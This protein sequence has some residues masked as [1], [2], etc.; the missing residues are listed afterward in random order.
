MNARKACVSFA[1]GIWTTVGPTVFAAAFA[2]DGLVFFHQQ[3]EPILR[4]RCFGCHSHRADPMEGG[5]SLDWRSG[6]ETGG[7]RG[8]AIAPG[9][10]DASLLIRAI[11]HVDNELQMPDEKLPDDEI[12]IL[13]RWVE[14]GAPDDRVVP[15]MS[16]DEALDWWSLNPLERPS[17][18]P[19]DTAT[20]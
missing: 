12:A 7:N 9:K 18:P 1:I 19:S 6:W 10:V 5:L 13:V 4:N 2:D 20:S 11:R 3:V 14:L 15:P 16:S 8:P 17:I